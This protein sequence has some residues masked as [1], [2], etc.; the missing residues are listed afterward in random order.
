MKAMISSH[1]AVLARGRSRPPAGFTLIELLVVIAIIAILAAM[2]LPALAKSKATA[3][4]AQCLSNLKQLGLGFRM[5]CQDQNDKTFPLGFFSA[6]APFWMKLLR[7][8]H[9]NVDKIRL[10]PAT[11]EPPALSARTPPPAGSTI[12]GSSTLAWWGA[13]D[14]FITGFS[15]SYGLNGWFYLDVNNPASPKGELN[16]LSMSQVEHPS[17][18]P[19]F[20]DCN[21]VDSWPLEANPPPKNLNT[22]ETSGGFANDLGRFI[23]NR[24]G[25]VTDLVFDDG[26]AASPRLEA[27]WSFYWHRK[28]VPKERVP[29]SGTAPRP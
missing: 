27:M 3:K 5:Y 12:W 17:M 6:D 18:V 22:G 4:R 26:H 7:D 11:R 29:L 20:G 10:C 21:W 8:N 13:K 1:P 24:H 28:W 2:L 19:V 15:G 9:G 23:M 25:A 16:Y 14:T